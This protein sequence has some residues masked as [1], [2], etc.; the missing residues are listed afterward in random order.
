M[1]LFSDLLLACQSVLA[2]EA[3]ARDD[4]EVVLLS[5]VIFGACFEKI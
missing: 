4:S 2:G 3:V 1:E 5:S